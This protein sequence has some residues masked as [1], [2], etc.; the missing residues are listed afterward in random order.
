MPITYIGGNY[1]E[2]GTGADLTFTLPTT[3]EDDLILMFLFS[4]EGGTVPNHS[5]SGYTQIDQRN[6]ISGGDRVIS[7]WRKFAGASESNPTAQDTTSSEE[8]SGVIAV[9]RG[10]DTTTP[11]DVSVA[12]TADVNNGGDSPPPPSITP[13]TDNGALAL[14][15]GIDGDAPSWAAPSGY[16]QG[17]FGR[18]NNASSCAAYDEDYGTAELHSPGS[19]STG[20]SSNKEY[21][22]YTVAL[23]PAGAAAVRRIF[24]IS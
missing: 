16:T 17:A 12:I 18:Q 21:G 10:V 15:M 6:L 7:L 11:L 13:V 19:F 14:F 3:Q 20:A 24:V 2:S 23:R 1:Q 4:D 8:W 5:V 9:F 22:G